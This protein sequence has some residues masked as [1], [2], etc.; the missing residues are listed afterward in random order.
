MPGMGQMKQNRRTGGDGG[1]SRR[2]QYW[3]EDSQVFLTSVATGQ[4]DDPYM[5]SYWLYTFQENG[6]WT[7]VLSDKE[8]PLKPVPSGTKPSY[9]F[10]FW[11]FI[12]NVIHTSKKNDDW[13]KIFTP[14]GEE[15][16]SEE[17][18]EFRFC[19]LPFGKDDVYY[20][21]TVD[22]YNDY[23]GDLTKGAIKITRRGSG[24][25]TNYSIAAQGSL[26]VSIPDEELAKVS[27]LPTADD[28]MMDNYCVGQSSG[29]GDVPDGAV[30]TNSDAK[31]NA[32]AE[33]A[34]GNDE[35]L[36]WEN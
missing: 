25:N 20:N 29:G 6:T 16:F 10:G 34:S 24:R 23:G 15:R 26:D 14:S 11:A 13:E 7:K 5:G 32:S 12:H 30:S 17:V 1:G 3:L 21:D 35:K 8:G 4:D 9:R 2:E 27:D 31:V 28:Y 19:I 18:N 33:A 22:I 36:P